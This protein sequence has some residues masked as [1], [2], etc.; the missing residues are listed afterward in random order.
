MGE[1]KRYDWTG[2]NFPTMIDVGAFV[3]YSD[4][5]KL[6]ATIAELTRERDALRGRTVFTEADLRAVWK[7]SRLNALHG[8]FSGFKG[9]DESIHALIQSKVGGR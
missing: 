3:L 2:N 1:V 8:P 7:A 4:Y 6:E 9:E 5:A